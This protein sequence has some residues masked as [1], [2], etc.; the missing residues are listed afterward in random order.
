ME[1]VLRGVQPAEDFALAPGVEGPWFDGVF[2]DHYARI[3]ALLARLTGDRAQAEEVAA[4]VFSKLSRQPGLLRGRDDVTAWIYRVATNAGLDALR[5][6]SRRRRRKQ[7]AGGEE[8]RTG[9]ADSA[10]DA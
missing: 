2:R 6:N 1:I 9:S 7:E 5:A 3:V 10:L 4:D 8:M